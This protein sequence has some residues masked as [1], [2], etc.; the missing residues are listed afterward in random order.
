MANDPVLN[1]RIHMHRKHV[2]DS[3]IAR[4]GVMELCSILPQEVG[5]KLASLV[6]KLALSRCV[7]LEA[8]FLA[9]TNEA[10][11]LTVLEMYAGLYT[12][13]LRLDESPEINDL[14][15]PVRSRW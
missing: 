9:L 2:V 15:G 1:N 14:D 3:Y 6:I 4:E 8:A 5:N 11:P 13:L 7:P 12:L 10:P